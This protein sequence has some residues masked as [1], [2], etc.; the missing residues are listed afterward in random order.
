MVMVVV[1]ITTLA[2]RFIMQ[3]IFEHGQPIFSW[4]NILFG[5]T[6]PVV[7]V[8]VG[9]KITTQSLLL[10][11]LGFAAAFTLIDYLLKVYTDWP[12]VIW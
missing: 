10:S 11:A 9:K 2:M 4:K 12:A 5:L 8:F 3:L 7:L 6:L 1:T